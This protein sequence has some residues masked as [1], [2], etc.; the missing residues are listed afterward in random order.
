MSKPYKVGIYCRLSRDDAANPAKIKNYIPGDESV[1]IENQY[2]MLSK[3]VMLRGWKEVR[4]SKK[5]GY[6]GGNFK[7][8]GFLG[9][10]GDA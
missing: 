8:P 10:M 6:S 9:R 3:F 4:R 7:R 1:S 5:A 2:E